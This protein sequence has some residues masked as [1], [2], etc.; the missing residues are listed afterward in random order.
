MV[1]SDLSGW[2]RY[3]DE[4]RASAKRH[5]VR[6]FFHAFPDFSRPALEMAAAE[7]RPAP[8]PHFFATDVRQ[9]PPALNDDLLELFGRAGQIL[10]NRFAFYNSPVDFKYGIEWERVPSPS[11]RA[12][13]HACDYVL[14]LACTLRI[15]GEDKYARHLR[16]LVAHW[17]AWNPPAQGSGWELPA[18]A[19]RLRNWML[20]ADLAREDWQRDAE[21]SNLV[22]KS[23]ALQAAYLLS[24][25]DSL[26][27]PGAAL[28]AAR[29]LLCASRFFHGSKAREAHRAGWELLV[30]SGRDGAQMRSPQEWLARAEALLEW[31]ILSQYDEE[32]LTL[33]PESQNA[34]DHLERLLS[35]AGTMS[36]LGTGA[37][38]A[39]DELSDVAALAA[40]TLQS[41]AWK[42]LAGKFGILPYL[43]LGESGKAQFESLPDID[44]V[45]RTDAPVGGEF[46]RLAGSQQSTV[47]ISARPPANHHDHHDFA[48]YELFINNSRVIVDSGGY[49]PEEQRY[50]P[51]A[52]AHNVLLL[53]DHEPRWHADHPAGVVTGDHWLRISSPGLASQGV[54]H[55]RLWLWLPSDSWLIVDRLDGLP[56]RRCTSLMHFYP[57]Y[58]LHPVN[59]RFVARSRACEFAVIPVGASK[60]SG[61][62]L[63]GDDPQFPGWF[64]PEYGVKFP[65]AVLALE[66]ERIQ[67]PWVG[68]VVIA[69]EPG[70]LPVSADLAFLD[71]LWRLEFCG[72][73]FE[74]PIR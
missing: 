16:Y 58:E 10:Q 29:A 25:V 28:P 17:I 23:L 73:A 56:V 52:R 65:S 57:T 67:P 7:F 4:W 72:Q 54:Q 6:W 35:A 51:G 50:F 74:L 11:W 37:R 15:S 1:A 44:W 30:G 22:G 63:G 3:L 20:A 66:W 43:S 60:P 5:A 59:D 45:P 69:S 32:F 64:S 70:G 14:D 19:R 2:E 49:S 39:A 47:L 46:L 9:I 61:R 27:S 24:Q 48:S 33:L 36:L 21:F 26:P 13:L 42:F 55:E 40:V 53:D 38:L 31:N 8:M 12:E 68:G 62:V 71:G 41:P 18:L 34:L